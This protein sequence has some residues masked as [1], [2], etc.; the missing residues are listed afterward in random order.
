MAWFARG[1]YFWVYRVDCMSKCMGKIKHFVTLCF[2]L[3]GLSLA[4]LADGIDN[5]KSFYGGNVITDPDKI[6]VW[7][8]YNGVWLKE[9]QRMHLPNG[10]FMLDKN[11][12]NYWRDFD[13]WP[14]YYTLGSRNDDKCI[15]PNDNYRNHYVVELRD[16]NDCYNNDV[17]PVPEPEIGVLLVGWLMVMG[18]IIARRSSQK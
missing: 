15:D 18:S 12:I 17:K 5:D 9:L 8:N 7:R 2:L 10:N 4:C 3:S 14:C 16:N 1:V 6:D 11:N 13:R